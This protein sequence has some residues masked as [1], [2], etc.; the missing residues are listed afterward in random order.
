MT[1]LLSVAELAARLPPNT[2]PLVVATGGLDENRIL[3]ALEEATGVIVAHLPWLLA[4]GGE[5]ALPLPAQFAGAL[6]GVCVDLA[7]FRLNDAVTSSED[8]RKHY[9]TN[10]R[11]L[12][13]IAREHQGGLVGPD[14]QAAEIVEPSE[15]EGIPDSRFWKKREFV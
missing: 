3:L 10:I 2:L 1:P 13:T 11:L 12:E 6:A 4:E 9:E 8:A 14:Y 15:S 7:V 5:V